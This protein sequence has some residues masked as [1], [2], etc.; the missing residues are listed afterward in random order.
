MHVAR[1]VKPAMY[2]DDSLSIRSYV[3]VSASC[4]DHQSL[5]HSIPIDDGDLGY[6]YD[7]C[8]CLRI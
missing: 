3:D 2:Y 8:C 6:D 7:W 1:D 4:S 5:K